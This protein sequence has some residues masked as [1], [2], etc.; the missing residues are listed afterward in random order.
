MQVLLPWKILHLHTYRDLCS[1]NKPEKKRMHNDTT[2]RN[3][4]TKMTESRHWHE[5]CSWS[6]L[7]TV[8]SLSV[9]SDYYC[10]KS[11]SCYRTAHKTC[12][13]YILLIN[14]SSASANQG[15]RGKWAE[16]MGGLGSFH[17]ARCWWSHVCLIEV[18]LISPVS[19]TPLTKSMFTTVLGRNRFCCYCRRF[20]HVVWNDV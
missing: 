16:P 20:F 4:N 8:S 15:Q 17:T 14:R 2:M 7:I 5:L 12:Y 13:R 19:N 11:F 6:Q 1:P 18:R 9:C 3:Q 10:D